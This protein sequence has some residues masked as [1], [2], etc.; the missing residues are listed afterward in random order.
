MTVHL[1]HTGVVEFHATA[2][3]LRIVAEIELASFGKRKY[4]VEKWVPV[5]ELNG[6]ACRNHKDMGIEP[7]INL[8]NLGRGTGRQRS[9]GN[10]SAGADRR[11]PDNDI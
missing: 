5:W 2:L 1:N 7:F 6:R 3:A 10:S 8:R 11:K 4:V 9:G